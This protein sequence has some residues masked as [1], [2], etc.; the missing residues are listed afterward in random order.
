MANDDLKLNRRMLM[1][2]ATALSASGLLAHNAFA[3]DA[4]STP[5]TEV[6]NPEQTGTPVAGTPVPGIQHGDKIPPEFQNAADTDWL[7]ENRTMAQD[8]SVKGSAI[9]STTVDGLQEAWSL[10]VEGSGMFGILT[11]NP[12][13]LGN[14]VYL[15]DAMSNLYAVDRESGELLWNN[16]HD[17]AV[18]SGGPSGI[19][20]GYGVLVHAVGNAGVV[21]VDQETGEE[22]WAVDISGP[23]GEGICM[24]PLLYD[25]KVWISTVPFGTGE[26]TGLTGNRGMIHAL[27]IANGNVLWYWDTTTRNLWDQPT[28]NAGGGCWHPPAVNS[29]GEMFFAVANIYPFAG[30]E[31]VPSGEVHTGNNDYANN[32]VRLDPETGSLIWNT[33]ITGRDIFDLDNHLV[34][35]GTVDFGDGYTRELVLTSGKHGFVV[36]LDPESGAQFFRTPVGTHRN[37]QLQSIPDGET[38]E[39]WP[40]AFGG[41][42]TP[43][44]YQDNVVYV[45]CYENPTFYTTSGLGESLTDSSGSAKASSVLVAVDARNGST[46]WSTPVPSGAFAGM[47]VVNDLVF[48][49]ALDG[50]LRAYNTADG[51]LV[52]S[53][54]L[55]AG[56]NG[57]PA[58]SGDYLL[59]PAG[60]PLLPSSD[61]QGEPPAYK[62][63]LYA[64][65]LS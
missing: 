12:I 55:A 23:K 25:N 64:F 30:T 9:S 5:D 52:W 41:V 20:V 56:V 48:T 27:D 7:T 59:V 13:V 2:V 24:A 22:R 44:A 16:K 4:N 1:G 57:T 28:I 39:V 10:P 63:Q 17:L 34:A 42:E 33:N 51:S 15:L 36:G 31:T 40:G 32:V 47:T 37:D 38:I 46:L 43:F 29:K 60:G 45:A 35:S 14:R 53:K 3:Q 19:A 61:T 62:A 8:R 58:V 21:A 11:S 26:A 54:Q 65:K 18:P 50:L 6:G 49:A